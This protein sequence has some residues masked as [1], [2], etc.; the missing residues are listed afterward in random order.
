MAR[1]N[2]DSEKTLGHVDLA[3]DINRFAAT[4]PEFKPQWAA[5]ITLHIIGAGFDTLGMTLSSCI[6]D[7]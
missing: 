7:Q 6:L 2:Q 5:T 4:R 3:G 1:G